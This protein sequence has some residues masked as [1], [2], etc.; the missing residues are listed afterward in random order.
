M[1]NWVDNHLRVL[2][3]AEALADFLLAAKPPAVGGEEHAEVFSFEGIV[4]TWLEQAADTS[5]DAAALREAFVSSPAAR[6]AR[7]SEF[8]PGDETTA[9][10][11]FE[12]EWDP[13]HPHLHVTSL[14]FPTL[15]LL[16]EYEEPGRG[17]RGRD[18]I[19]A[20]RLLDRDR[21][22]FGPDGA[23]FYDACAPL[24]DV[25]APYLSAPW[26]RVGAATT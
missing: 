6:A 1:S 24:R 22:A 3:P 18:V 14:L 10:F 2:G 12:S 25:F 4:R 5:A 7:Y 13:P 16:H 19:R 20:G 8:F 15:T 23:D 17:F 26:R 11:D 21:G 9:A